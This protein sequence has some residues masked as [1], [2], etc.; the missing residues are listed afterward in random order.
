M[1]VSQPIN[2]RLP[3][4]FR[5]G[6]ALWI[7]GLMQPFPLTVTLILLPTIRVNRFILRLFGADYLTP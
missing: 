3:R 6:K 2:D 4:Y 1:A 7:M 5:S